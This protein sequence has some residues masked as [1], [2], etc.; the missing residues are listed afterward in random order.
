MAPQPNSNIIAYWFW[1]K[2]IRLCQCCSLMAT[3]YV[4]FNHFSNL[5]RGEAAELAGNGNFAQV[6]LQAG[7]C[8]M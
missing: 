5:A 6:A 3:F 2:K 4:K 1:L 7:F 8:V